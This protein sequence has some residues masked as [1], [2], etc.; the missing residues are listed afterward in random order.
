[1]LKFCGKCHCYFG[2]LH[3]IC[4]WLLINSSSPQMWYL[5]IYLCHPWFLSPVL[6]SFLRTGLF[7]SWL[8][9]CQGI[10][11]SLIKLW[12]LLLISL[13][14][15]SSLVKRNATGFCLL[16]CLLL[17]Y[18]HLLFQIFFWWSLG[19][20]VSNLMSSSNSGSFTFPIWMPFISCLIAVAR[21][22]IITLNKSG[23]SGFPCLVLD[24]RGKAF[25]LSPLSMVLTVNL[26]YVAFIVPTLLRVFIVNGCLSFIS[27]FLC[28]YWDDM[29]FFPFC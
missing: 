14:D 4:R 23:K 28:I 13:S 17:Y 20:S 10:L 15:S 25:H 26:S 2:G 7:P 16:V 18:I 19:F 11:F 8:N 24:L 21:T 5:S 22:F 12:I 3:W 27:C 9:L 1:M 29:I 6:H